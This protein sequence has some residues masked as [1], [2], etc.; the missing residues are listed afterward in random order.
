MRR[1]DRAADIK[2]DICRLLKEQT[3]DQRCAVLG[4]APVLISKVIPEVISGIFHD[5][6]NRDNALGHQIDPFNLGDRRDIALLKG[7]RRFERLIQILGDD[8]G[9]R[10]AADDML[11]RLGEKHGE[12]AIAIVP[13]C[14]PAAMSPRGASSPG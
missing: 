8:G 5:L 2:I 11:A 13:S 12:H 9:C 10:S 14:F 1:I 6:V 7:E 3:A 4:K